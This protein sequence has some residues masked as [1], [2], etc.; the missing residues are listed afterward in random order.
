MNAKRLSF[1][2]IARAGC[3]LILLGSC[4]KLSF[5]QPTEKENLQA[6]P[7]V[8]KFSER[9]EIAEPPRTF[10]ERFQDYRSATFSPWALFTPSVTA[11]LSQL[12]NYPPEWKQ[13]AEGF[14]K[15]VASG[16]GNEVAANTLSFG[17]SFVDHED[18]RYPLSTYPTSAIL[19]RTWHVLSF[20][21][22][23]R[24]D[25]GGRRFGLARLIGDYSAGFVANTWYPAGRST[26]KNAL[27]LGSVNLAGDLGVNLFKEFIRPH[28]V[29]G[30]TKK[31]SATRKKRVDHGQDS[32]SV[33]S[34]VSV[35]PVTAGEVLPHYSDPG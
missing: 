1:A 28:V 7:V 15:R 33:A 35:M 2:G 29:F 10:K 13:G 25:G 24:K 21:V 18:L 5:T 34:R 4:A 3:L 8:Q 32:A 12:R 9:P 17:F 27:Y 30:N 19:K 20:T 26:T 14:G 31:A 23:P 16:Y 11:G 6:K 22:V